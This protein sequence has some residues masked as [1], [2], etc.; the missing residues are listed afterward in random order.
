MRIHLEEGRTYKSITAEYD[1]SKA[2]ISEWHAEFSKEC[3]EKAVLNPNSPNEEELTKDNLQLRKE[4][5]E[6]K[7]K[8]S[9]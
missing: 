1:A 3:R 4:L 9:F 5:E 6:S 8:I 2:S 7:K